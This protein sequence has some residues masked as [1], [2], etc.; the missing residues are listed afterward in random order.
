M[1]GITKLFGVEEE[2][3]RSVTLSAG[4][5]SGLHFF[6]KTFINLS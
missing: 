6:P 2:R 5:G 3:V 4:S 1:H